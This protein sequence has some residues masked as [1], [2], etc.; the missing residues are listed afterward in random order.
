[1]GKLHIRTPIFLVR[2][3]TYHPNTFQ[4]GAK[5]DELFLGKFH[6]DLKNS[7]KVISKQKN[8][9]PIVTKS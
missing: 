2:Y 9:L 3:L 7:I 6:E 5:V 8:A 1:M 4:E